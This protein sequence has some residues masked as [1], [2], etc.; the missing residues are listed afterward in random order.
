MHLVYAEQRE[1]W[2][3]L[4]TQAQLD[5]CAV[6]ETWLDEEGQRILEYDVK[7]SQYQWF[8]KVEQKL[9]GRRGLGMLVRKC[10]RIAK[11]S[12][13]ADLLVMVGDQEDPLYVAVVYL[14]PK[15][16]SREC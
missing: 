6:V 1:A 10:P 5:V 3:E 14:V 8:G 13:S 12:V 2:L 4:T 11:K 9:V 7:D 15:Y 16:L